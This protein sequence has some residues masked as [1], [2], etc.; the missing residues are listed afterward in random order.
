MKREV[1]ER[2]LEISRRMAETWEL[3]PLLDYAMREAI[4]LVNAE[5]GFLVLLQKD[6]SLDFRVKL[7]QAGNQLED[8]RDQIST[9][10]LGKVVDTHQPVVIWDA[11]EDPDLAELVERVSKART[12]YLRWG[13]DTLGWAIYIFRLRRALFSSGTSWD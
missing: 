8:A 7:D 6:G 12:V 2:M 11:L 1:L 3:S 9:S 10:I 4:N 13:R 5:Y